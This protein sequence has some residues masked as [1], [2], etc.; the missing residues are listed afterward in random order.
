MMSCEYWEFGSCDPIIDDPCLCCGERC[1]IFEEASSVETKCREMGVVSQDWLTFMSQYLE[2]EVMMRNFLSQ[3][4]DELHNMHL[5]RCQ[6]VIQLELDIAG[7]KANMRK[8]IGV[9]RTP[10]QEA[11]NGKLEVVP[12][13]EG[14][15]VD[16]EEIM[17]LCNQAESIK[18]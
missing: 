12:Q 15:V 6:E 1:D 5:R 8:W 7:L 17:G 9:R 11:K 16:I 10:Y 18:I 3:K 2:R 13:E 14:V 4:M